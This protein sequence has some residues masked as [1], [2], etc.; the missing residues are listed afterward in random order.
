MDSLTPTDD[1]RDSDGDGVPDYIEYIEG[2]DP[3]DSSSR[4][5]ENEH[6]GRADYLD[7]PFATRVRYA[8]EI[9]TAGNVQVTVT[10]NKTVKNIFGWTRQSPTTFTKVYTTNTSEVVTFVD[11]KGFS[12]FTGVNV[13]WIT[14]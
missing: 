5:D 13:Y 8:P 3:R 12:G 14:G 7:P 6:N 1:W 9:Q 10:T 4:R 2:T 11:L